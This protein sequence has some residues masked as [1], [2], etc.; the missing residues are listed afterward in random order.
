MNAASLHLPVIALAIALCPSALLAQS[1]PKYEV[2]ASWPKDLPD[3]W[4]T[5]QLGG[6][7]VDAQ[8]NVIVVNRGDITDEE[9][10]TSK[11]APPIIKFDSA[12]KVIASWGDRNVVPRSIH[13]CTVDRDNNVWVAGNGDGI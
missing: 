3:G 10:E 4:I 12:G 8:D 6:I 11:G 5:G 2:D 7:C 13:G 9:K 1:A